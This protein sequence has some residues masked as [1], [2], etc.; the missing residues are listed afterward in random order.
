MTLPRASVFVSV[1]VAGEILFSEYSS[2]NSQGIK[3]K[4]SS[5]K[6]TS[7]IKRPNGKYCAKPLLK[8]ENEMLSIITTNRKSTAK[9]PMYTI[10]SIIAKNSAPNKIKNPATPKKASISQRTECTAL[11]ANITKTP[12]TIDKIAKK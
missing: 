3:A 7:P 11:F 2:L 6:T 10:I 1:L 9:A 4:E 8:P 12:E 5:T